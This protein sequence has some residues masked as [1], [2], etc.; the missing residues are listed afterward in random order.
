MFS[1]EFLICVKCNV[2]ICVICAKYDNFLKGFQSDGLTATSNVWLMT[3]PLAKMDYIVL[4]E[5]ET[6]YDRV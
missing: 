2:C 3:V 1:N 6:E 4:N 5:V